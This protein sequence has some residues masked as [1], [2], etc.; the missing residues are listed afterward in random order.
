[1]ISCLPSEHHLSHSDSRPV[2]LPI[3]Q[4]SE[5]GVLHLGLLRFLNLNFQPHYGLGVD[6]ASNRNECRESSWGI[7]GGWREGLTALPP[8]VSR[9]S[10]KCRS[11]DVWQPYG[12]PQLVT[13]IALPYLNFLTDSTVT[14]LIYLRTETHPVS[15]MLCSFKILDEL[16]E[17]CN[18][19]VT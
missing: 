15:K 1:M 3:L 4:S 11:L 17:C 5:D 2:N 16:Q 9:L 18:L 8:P 13:G 7:K 6:S 10:R 14:Q 12:P 19:L